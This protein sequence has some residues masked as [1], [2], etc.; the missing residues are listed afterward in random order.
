M[1]QDHLPRIP[2]FNLAGSLHAAEA[3]VDRSRQTQAPDL[4]RLL[5]KSS[6]DLLDHAL[7]RS[8]PTRRCYSTR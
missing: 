5:L 6:C 7:T 4:Q 8:E 2:A 1:D 3:M